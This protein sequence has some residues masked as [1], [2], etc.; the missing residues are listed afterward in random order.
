MNLSVT[1]SYESIQAEPVM[2]RVALIYNPFSGQDSPRRKTAID[3]ALDMLSNAGIRA[4]AMVTD[5]PGSAGALAA[6]F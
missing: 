4:E 3:C 5:G 2:R 1:A 6:T